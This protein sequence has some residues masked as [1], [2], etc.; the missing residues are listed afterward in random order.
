MK[1]GVSNNLGSQVKGYLVLLLCCMLFACS[2]EGDLEGIEIYHGDVD[3]SGFITVNV[4]PENKKQKIISIGGNYPQANYTTQA[5]DLVGRNTIEKF[6]PT[7]VRVALPLQFYGVS[8]ENYKGNK[9]LTQPR[10]VSLL[11]AMREMK[12]DYGVVNFTV[13]VW[14]VANEL[15]EN[16]ED[17]NKRRI[18]PDKY[19]EV[20]D[21]IEAF[22]LEAKNKYGVEI[23]YF[24]FNESNGGYM[25]LFTPQQSITFIK[26]AGERFE[27]SGLKTIFLWG[28]TSSTKTTVAFASAIAADA[29]VLKYLGPLSFHSWWSEEEPDAIFEEVANL[30]STFNRPVWCTE[31]GHDAIAHQTPGY[32]LNWNYAFRF[33]KISSR[34]FRYSNTEVSMFWTWQKNYE[35]M[36]ADTLTKYPIYYL[37]RHQ[38]DFLNKVQLVE[39][40]CS[41]SDILS[42]VGFN[43]NN[44]MVLQLINLKSE[45]V[46]LRLTN[47]S[48][49]TAHMVTSVESNLWE[50]TSLSF[51]N[52]PN[53]I[54]LTLK[55]QSVNTVV[56]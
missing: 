53:D 44:K 20:I 25:T 47:V 16:P 39:S 7:H 55:A 33:A 3:T 14:R 15:V 36:S 32:N 43:E 31:L 11:E 23:D 10:V 29:G 54:Y 26:M 37:T 50:Q 52:G 12:E 6:K 34:V 27:N 40:Q 42:L 21:M 4:F 17:Q 35:I 19:V 41:D 51:A 1:L 45:P 24:S 9:I 48:G 2:K 56:F 18:K 49:T 8:Y 5:W 28:D 13:S 22:L 46:T 38:T 30:A